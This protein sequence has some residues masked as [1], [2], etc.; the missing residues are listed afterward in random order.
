MDGA[1]Y[2]IQGNRI[3]PAETIKE[4]NSNGPSGAFLGTVPDDGRE[5]DVPEGIFGSIWR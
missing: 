5:D 3:V 2:G 4:F 1:A